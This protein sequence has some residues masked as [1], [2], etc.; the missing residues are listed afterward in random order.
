MSLLC[1]VCGK[2]FAG[3]SEEQTNFHV[4]SC[5]DRS[6]GTQIVVCPYCTTNLSFYDIADREQHTL[7]CGKDVECDALFETSLAEKRYEQLQS[8]CDGS[9]CFV[10]DVSLKGKNQKQVT[11][12]LSFCLG[13][14]VQQVESIFKDTKSNKKTQYL[15]DRLQET[16]DKIDSEIDALLE[17]KRKLQLKLERS[18][19]LEGRIRKVFS[20]KKIPNLTK[21]HQNACNNINVFSIR[22]PRPSKFSSLHSHSVVE[23]ARQGTSEKL[24]I[25]PD[26]KRPKVDS[27]EQEDIMQSKER[28]D[29]ISMTKERL[30]VSFLTSFLLMDRK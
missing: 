17:A 20:F 28:P 15:S 12:H 2:D 9:V 21:N 13:I 27:L 22:K 29:F 4:N 18:L 19:V 5:L 26:L 16:V 1:F 14:S 3:M 24:Q 11:K 7:Q 30:A 8:D 25:Q 23:I 6:Q 10:C